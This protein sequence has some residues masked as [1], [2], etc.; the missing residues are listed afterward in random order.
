MPSTSQVLRF[1]LVGAG[2]IAREHLNGILKHP[3]AQLAAVADIN[4]AAATTL[5]QMCPEPPKI[6]AD[7]HE[8]LSAASLD[9]VVVCTPPWLHEQITIDALNAGCNVLC[10]K[11]HSMSVE[12]VERMLAAAQRSGKMLADCSCRYLF[13]PI[14]RKAVAFVESGVLGDIYHVRFTMRGGFVRPGIE[15]NPGAT[16]FFER[17]KA[18]G[19]VLLDWGVY[20]LAAIFTVLGYPQVKFV[21][22]FTYSGMDESK[23]TYPTFDVEE[24]GGAMIQTADGV[25]IH[26]EHAWASH[27]NEESGLL[28]F[29]S[30]AGMAFPP[31]QWDRP[32]SIELIKR[33]NKETY[34]EKIT[35]REE[36]QY[37][38]PVSDFIDALV[39]NRLP[40]MPAERAL[41]ALR[42]I[43]AVYES[44]ATGAPV[45]L[46][47]HQA[48]SA[49]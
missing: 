3:N 45:N 49:R 19:G 31:V 29:G 23:S 39:N 35:T 16:W 20:D 7:Y 38:N 21:T 44:Q 6:Y 10:E 12:S 46:S 22:G 11:P 18:G 40:A 13:N 2:M 26:W 14:I 9:A 4:A 36:D 34:V 27:M 37:P 48:Q 15:Y 28:V 1:G 42:V 17:V 25:C 43:F 5:A 32:R 33:S 47:Q 8:M 30:R 41:A 24:H